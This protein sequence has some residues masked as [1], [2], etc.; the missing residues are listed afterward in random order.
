MSADDL[1]GTVFAGHHQPL[2]VWML[3]LYF[4]GLNL[5]HRQIAQELALNPG[6]V[7]QMTEQCR[8]GV[9][10]AQPEP[11]LSGEVECDEGYVVP[12]IRG[13]PRRSRP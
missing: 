9:V 13:S 7:Q 8:T 3:C 6:D 11:S 4:M 5:S 2:R 1:T 10:A 12:A